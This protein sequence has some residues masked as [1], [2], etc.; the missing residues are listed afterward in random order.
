MSGPGRLSQP[1][2]DSREMENTYAVP[3][4]SID[5]NRKQVQISIDKLID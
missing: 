4:D 2:L 5:N 3:R 1:G